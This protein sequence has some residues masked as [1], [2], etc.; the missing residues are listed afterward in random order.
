MELE[1]VTRVPQSACC[2]EGL[3][4][5][6]ESKMEQMAKQTGKCLLYLPDIGVPWLPHPLFI[7]G[8]SEHLGNS[9]KRQKRLSKA[10]VEPGLWGRLCCR[11]KRMG[12]SIFDN[13]Q[14]ARCILGLW[15]AILNWWKH[16]ERMCFS[17]IKS[18]IKQ[19]GTKRGSLGV[20]C[21]EQKWKR[22]VPT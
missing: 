18:Q 21:L 8:T 11:M 12:F 19:M 2:L 16:K 1:P 4:V 9:D 13:L 17:C 15:I 3:N 20:G 5:V 10:W 6:L 7:L 22:L 14:E